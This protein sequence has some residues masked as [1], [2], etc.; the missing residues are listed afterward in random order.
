FT[1]K[2]GASLT[3][4]TNINGATSP[5]ARAT[6]RIR[7][8][9]IAGLDIGRMIF[10]SVSDLVAPSA[11]EPSRSDRG[12]RVR[13]SSVDTITTGTVSRARVNDA[14][15]IPPVPKVG[16]GSASGKNSVS[17]LPPRK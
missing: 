17:I 16:V 4:P 15:S 11:N 13:P 8:V 6:A 7:P 14:Q 9:I 3:T 2:D 10:H 5:A 12:I 1:A